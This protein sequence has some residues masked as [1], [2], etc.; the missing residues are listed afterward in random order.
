VILSGL[1]DYDMVINNLFARTAFFVTFF[2]FKDNV[3][4]HLYFHKVYL[5]PLSKCSFLII[6]KYKSIYSI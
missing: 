1:F 5:I 6:K 2:L 4:S 3:L